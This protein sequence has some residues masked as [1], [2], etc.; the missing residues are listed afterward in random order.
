MSFEKAVA[1]MTNGQRF[2]QIL[3]KRIEKYNQQAGEKIE[4]DDA[5]ARNVAY[6]FSQFLSEEFDVPTADKKLLACEMLSAFVNHLMEL[7]WIFLRDGNRRKPF[8]VP[9]T[10]DDAIDRLA[11]AELITDIGIV[12]LTEMFSRRDFYDH[13][14][15]YSGPV[16]MML[17]R[18]GRVHD[19][20]SLL[21]VDLDPYSLFNQ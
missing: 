14:R 6:N 13:A 4:Y 19:F 17:A 2:V 15:T 12:V 1:Y 16:S 20:A 8:G 3:H 21:G 9:I 7:N 18:D 5:L 10:P 11:A